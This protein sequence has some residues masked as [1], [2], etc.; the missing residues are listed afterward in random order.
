MG[1][2]YE[3]LENVEDILQLNGAHLSSI[4]VLPDN[5]STT[6][7]SDEYLYSSSLETVRKLAKQNDLPLTIIGKNED[8]ELVENR[9]VEWFVPVLFISSLYY[10]QNPEAVTIAL[11]MLANYLTK[12]F[13]TKSDTDVNLKVILQDEETKKTKKVKYKGPAE[14]LKDL[15][16]VIESTFKEIKKDED[17]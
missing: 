17:N 2:E 5:Y 6:K 11:N 14:G 8:Y 13:K 9:A 7:N 16:K 3:D 4:C 15:D 1:I 10:S 12:L